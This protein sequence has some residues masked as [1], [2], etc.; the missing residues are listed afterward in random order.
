MTF[1][2]LV[3]LLTYPDMTPLAGIPR[4]PGLAATLEAGLTVIIHEVDI[5]LIT[6]PF[7]NLVLD[8]KAMSNAAEALSRARVVELA[9][10]VRQCAEKIAL[11]VAIETIRA[12]RLSDELIATRANL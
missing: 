6:E 3:R 12:P 9:Q 2:I 8:V 5:P 1:R 7:A 4:A 11:G 10:A